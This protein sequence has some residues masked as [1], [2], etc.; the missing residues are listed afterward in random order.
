MF[1]VQHLRGQFPSAC[2]CGGGWRPVSPPERKDEVPKYAC[3]PGVH[4]SITLNS[5]PVKRA[6]LHR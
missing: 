5:Q 1:W 3:G 6:S 4:R 2:V